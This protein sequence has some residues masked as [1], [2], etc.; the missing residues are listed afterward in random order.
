MHIKIHKHTRARKLFFFILKIQ[1]ILRL[2]F[3]YIDETPM[4]S[5]PADA[6]PVEAAPVESAPAA[7]AAPAAEVAPADAAAA[8]AADGL[9]GAAKDATG[10]AN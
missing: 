2:F 1:F 6:A 10:T 8:P 9:V 5:A 7:D 4:E 3:V